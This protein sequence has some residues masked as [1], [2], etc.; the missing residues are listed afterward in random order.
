ML[1]SGSLSDPLVSICFRSLFICRFWSVVQPFRLQPCPSNTRTNP[2]AYGTGSSILVIS[3]VQ[4]RST[5]QQNSEKWQRQQ[6]LCMRIHN[7]QT[8]SFPD[9]QTSSAQRRPND[10]ASTS[11]RWRPDHYFAIPCTTP[12]SSFLI[13]PYALLLRK[14]FL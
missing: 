9:N 13:A 10:D 1:T 2:I 8:L 3:A 11:C 14:N 5:H 7:H 4:T 6:M 12:P